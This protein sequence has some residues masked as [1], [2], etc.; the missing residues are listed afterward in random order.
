ME[1]EK[2][3]KKFDDDSFTDDFVIIGLL[4]SIIVQMLIDVYKGSKL[5]KERAMAFFRSEEYKDVIVE[6]FRTF[7]V[8]FATM[9]PGCDGSFHAIADILERDGGPELL[10]KACRAVPLVEGGVQGKALYVRKGNKLVPLPAFGAKGLTG[11]KVIQL[12]L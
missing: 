7:N 3:E 2:K 1:E 8:K 9:F 10:Y 12:A 11:R 4:G 6:D 5:Q